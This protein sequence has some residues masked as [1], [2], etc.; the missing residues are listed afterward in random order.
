MGTLGSSRLSAASAKQ[1]S[2]SSFHGR[3]FG[4]GSL[5]GLGRRREPLETRGARAES[6]TN[7]RMREGGG[8][9]RGRVRGQVDVLARGSPHREA[10]VQGGDRQVGR[11]REVLGAAFEQHAVAGDEEALGGERRGVV[12]DELHASRR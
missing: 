4:G 10:A 3:A 6:A 12:L 8:D 2:S 5:D 1:A 11:L 7:Y 9:A